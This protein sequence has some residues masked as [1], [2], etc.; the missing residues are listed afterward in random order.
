MFRSGYCTPS[1]YSRQVNHSQ[2]LRKHV[3]GGKG[4]LTFHVLVFQSPFLGLQQNLLLYPNKLCLRP[5]IYKIGDCRTVPI[6]LKVGNQR[7]TESHFSFPFPM[8]CRKPGA[9]GSM[10]IKHPVS[11]ASFQRS[12]KSSP[13]VGKE[14]VHEAT[15]QGL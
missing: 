3:R 6:E 14:H 7:A 8:I 11:L 13:N 10:I 1:T 4:S 5:Q 15:G 9:L 12:E 2:R